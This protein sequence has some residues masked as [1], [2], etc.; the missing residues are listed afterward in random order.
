MASDIRI[1]DGFLDHPKTIKLARRVGELAPIYVLRFWLYVA[2][3]HADGDLGDLSDEDIEIACRWTGEPGK[4]AAAL[5]EVGYIDGEFPSRFVHDWADHQPWVC[6]RGERIESARNAAKS[7]WEKVRQSSQVVDSVDSNAKR[8][9]GACEADA[10]RNAPNPTQPN[11][12]PTQQEQKQK[13]PPSRAALA[14]PDWLPVDQWGAFVEMRKRMKA[15]LTD[16]AISLAIGELE[17]LRAQG[18][19]VGK[20]LDQSTANGWKGLFPLKTNGNGHHRAPPSGQ[21][22]YLDDSRDE[23]LAKMNQRMQGNGS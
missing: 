15:P 20:V 2:N 5:A 4:L 8:M 7:R 17:K 9:R 19:D 16:R 3:Q 6:K 13:Q 21:R 12:N 18:H 11:P 22:D 10:E 23:L 1:M 14:L